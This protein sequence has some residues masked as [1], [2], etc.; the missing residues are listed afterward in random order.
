MLYTTRGH[1]FDF[2]RLR[3][4]ARAASRRLRSRSACSSTASHS[5]S[6]C[7][8]VVAVLVSARHEAAERAAVDR[9]ARLLRLVGLALPGPARAYRPPVDYDAPRCGIGAAR[10]PAGA[11]SR[12]LLTR[13]RPP[14]SACSAFFKYFGFFVECSPRD[15]RTRSA[16]APICSDAADHPAGRHLVLHLPDALLHDRRLSRAARS[17]RATCSTS[18]S[19]SRSSR[20]WWPGP[21]VRAR[22]SAAAVRARRGACT[23]TTCAR[24]LTLDRCGASSR[25]S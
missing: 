20:S 12:A 25:R 3:L 1:L 16:G 14:T 24:G 7:R 13:P 15:A 10:E 17:R 23:R 5:P 21:I 18:P 6:S 22:D 9:A 11:A 2:A 8:G 4:T 19:S